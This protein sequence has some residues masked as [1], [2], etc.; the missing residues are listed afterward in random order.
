MPITLLKPLGSDVYNIDVFNK[1]STTIEKYLNQFE[2]DIAVGFKIHYYP[3]SGNTFNIDTAAAGIHVCDDLPF[4]NLTGTFPTDESKWYFAVMV[5]GQN[6]TSWTQLFVD[7]SNNNNKVYIRSKLHNDV[8][9]TAWVEIATGSGGGSGS[10]GLLVS[11]FSSILNM[12]TIGSGI[13]L[14]DGATLAEGSTLPETMS[15][16]TLYA[17][18]SYGDGDNVLKV[19]Q[20][21]NLTAGVDEYYTRVRYRNSESAWNWTDWKKLGSGEP[22][23]GPSTDIT[24]SVVDV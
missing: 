17:F 20:I 8:S 24:V 18:I 1:N 9:W 4:A 22:G 14:C 7:L 15:D 19:Q 16:S 10:S 2:A 21:V 23:P 11:Y 5:F 6:G 13:Y 12:D 3:A